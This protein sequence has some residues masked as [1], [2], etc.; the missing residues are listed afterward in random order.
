MQA[1][2]SDYSAIMI[3]VAILAGIAICLFYGCF[4]STEAT[5]KKS[6]IHM[7]STIHC[8]S[9]NEFMETGFLIAPEGITWSSN[10]PILQGENLFEHHYRFTYN[11]VKAYLCRG[12][13]IIKYLPLEE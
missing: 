3:L 13:G 11:Y 7:Y 9:C 6:S 1:L 12:C 8:P 4:T 5:E 10:L 2:P